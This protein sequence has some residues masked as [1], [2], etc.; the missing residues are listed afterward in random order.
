MNSNGTL[1]DEA[2]NQIREQVWNDEVTSITFGKL[3]DMAGIEVTSEELLDMVIG[4][5]IAP[6][7]RQLFTNP[8]TGV[9][10][11]AQAEVHVDA[12]W[13]VLSVIRDMLA[14]PEAPSLISPCY[15]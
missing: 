10:D 4:Q 12:A 15:Y 11:K 9:Y 1:S 13:S 6:V 8:Q 2:Q 3:Y 14:S 5:N 7:L